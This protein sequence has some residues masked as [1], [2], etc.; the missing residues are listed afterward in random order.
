MSEETL[1]EFAKFF[2][3]IC[4]D[5]VDFMENLMEPDRL[6]ARLLMWAEEEARI[7]GFTRRL[8][9]FWRRSSIVE[10]CREGNFPACST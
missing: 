10:S 2:L 3:K 4:I 7:G 1:A 5:Q 9:R 6:R 8:G